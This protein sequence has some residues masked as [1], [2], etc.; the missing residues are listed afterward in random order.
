MDRSK[1]PLHAWSSRDLKRRLEEMAATTQISYSSIDDE[2]RSRK[3]RMLNTLL[4]LAICINSTIV[5]LDLIPDII[6]SIFGSD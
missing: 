6:K 5:A 1:V 2:L 3:T 4:T